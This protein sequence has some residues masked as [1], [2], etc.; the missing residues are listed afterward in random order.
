MRLSH[1]NV[2]F[3]IAHITLLPRRAIELV[4]LERNVTFAEHNQMP[5]ERRKKTQIPERVPTAGDPDRK[6]VL[7]VL[8][9]RRYRTLTP[10]QSLWKRVGQIYYDMK[11]SS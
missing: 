11:R 8:A 3:P 7:N 4:L 9:Q 1:H 5:A 6:R 10:T 2:M